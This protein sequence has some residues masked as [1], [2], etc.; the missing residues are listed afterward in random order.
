MMGCLAMEGQLDVVIHTATIQGMLLNISIKGTPS[1]L[2]Y[3]L[4]I[5]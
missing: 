1:N 3:V 5:Q 2:H 4:T